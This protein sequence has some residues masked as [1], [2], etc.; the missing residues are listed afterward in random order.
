MNNTKNYQMVLWELNYCQQWEL[1]SDVMSSGVNTAKITVAIP[2]RY[3][4]ITSKK[5]SQLSF[6]KCLK[7]YHSCRMI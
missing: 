5:M 6:L 7:K 2:P 3:W 1:E 4:I